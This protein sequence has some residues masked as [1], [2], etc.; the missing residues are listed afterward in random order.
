MDTTVA[1]GIRRP[2][3]VGTPP[4]RSG[5]TMIRSNV[6]RRWYGGWIE[7]LS[8]KPRA[9]IAPQFGIA[10]VAAGMGSSRSQA[11]FRR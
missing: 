4:I 3:I 2:R 10:E 9:E 7:N 5:S 8:T 11:L 1:T 6:T